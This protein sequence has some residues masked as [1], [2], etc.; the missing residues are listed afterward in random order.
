MSTPTPKPPPSGRRKPVSFVHRNLPLLLLRARESVLARFRPILNAHGLTEQQWRILRALLESGP[1]EPRQ[2]GRLCGISSPS[3]AGI[4]ARMEA[5]DLIH[6]QRLEHDQ[7]RV[8]VTP[9]ARGRA[10]VRQMAP[11]IE[12]EYAELEVQLGP[13]F[14]ARVY[15]TLDELLAQLGSA[16][17]DAG[18][19]DAP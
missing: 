15:A 12:A 19:A 17:A 18:E 1:L 4:L 8:L 10:V 13:A 2:I 6:R 9:S 3:M 16:E 14:V 11:L 7:R 5:L